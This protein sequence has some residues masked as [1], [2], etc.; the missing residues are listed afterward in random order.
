MSQAQEFSMRAYAYIDSMQPEFAAYVGATV[1]G[2]PPVAGMAELW[3]EVAPA[4][5]AF[6]LMDVA[7]KA[8]DVQPATQFIEREFGLL[9]LHSWSQSEVKAAAEAIFSVTGLTEDDRVRPQLASQQV[10]TNVDPF[11]AQLINK[12]RRGSLLVPGQTLLIMEVEPAA[13]ITLA[14][15]EA[16]KAAAISQVYVSNVGRFGRYFAAG[17]DSEIEAARLSAIAAIEAA[18]RA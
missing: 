18:G 15:N 13:Y 3:I 6:R 8:A 9:E 4:N 11:Q 10:V 14:A 1:Q 7:L 17:N 5:E 12:M 16:E 2:S